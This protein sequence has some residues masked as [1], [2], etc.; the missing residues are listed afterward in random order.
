[1]VQ[2]DASV[3]LDTE[4]AYEDDGV[5]P[6]VDD[7]GNQVYITYATMQ[8]VH[9]KRGSCINGSDVVIQMDT[10]QDMLSEEVARDQEGIEQAVDLGINP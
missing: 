5:T 3:E 4:P 7:D 6:Q 8:V 10:L 2:R 1:M 9:A